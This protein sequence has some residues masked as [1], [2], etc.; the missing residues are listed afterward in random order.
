MVRNISELVGRPIR[1]GGFLNDGKPAFVSAA[2]DITDHCPGAKAQALLRYSQLPRGTMVEVLDLTEK[3]K[4]EGG[5]FGTHFVLKEWD[6]ARMA[7][8]ATLCTIA[9]G[10]GIAPRELAK[11]IFANAPKA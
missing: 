4:Y 3:G 6:V 9:G 8:N 2:V 10:W 7:G 5:Y 1:G 11:L